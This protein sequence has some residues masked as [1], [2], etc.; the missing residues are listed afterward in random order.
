MSQNRESAGGAASGGGGAVRPRG[1]SQS[2]SRHRGPSQSVSQEAMVVDDLDRGGGARNDWAKGALWCIPARSEATEFRKYALAEIAKRYSEAGGSLPVKVYRSD[3]T[4]LEYRCSSIPNKATEKKTKVAMKEAREEYTPFTLSTACKF[5]VKFNWYAQ[6]TERDKPSG[7]YLTELNEDHSPGCDRPER[8]RHLN[9]KVIEAAEIPALTTFSLPASGKASGA[10][11]QLQEIASKS[12]AGAGFNVKVSKS[13]ARKYVKRLK[14][15]PGKIF[16]LRR[17]LPYQPTSLR[18]EHSDRHLRRFLLADCADL[19][20][21]SRFWSVRQGKEA[22]RQGRYREKPNAVPT[23]SC[24]PGN[25]CCFCYC[26][27]RR[28]SRP[29]HGEEVEELLSRQPRG[30]EERER[31]AGGGRGRTLADVLASVARHGE[32]LRDRGSFTN[33]PA[34]SS[35]SPFQGLEGERLLG[36]RGQPL[37]THDNCLASRG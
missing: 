13:H 34:P 24:S 8:A 31:A 33:S 20:S 2:V 25:S 27:Y 22:I 19:L 12:S 36:G 28:I 1:H 16:V 29:A 7:W 23:I 10:A 21:L 35:P 14:E 11:G 15:G 18:A 37:R 3:S 5:C 9:Y 30:E 32:Q 4:R 26:H 17:P 6:K